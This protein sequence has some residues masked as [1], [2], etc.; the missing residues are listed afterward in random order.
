VLGSG[1]SA[2]LISAV[3]LIPCA[4]GIM[5]SNRIVQNYY[6]LHDRLF[7]WV[8][9]LVPEI[10]TGFEVNP[11]TSANTNIVFQSI[12]MPSNP[13][14]T[15]FVYFGVLPAV[16][17]LLNF[18]IPSKG[19]HRFWKIYSLAA[20]AIAL[21]FQPVWGFLSILFFPLVHYSY[22][23]IILPLGLCMLFGYTGI[24]L[25]KEKFNLPHL[26][27]GLIGAL[28]LAQALM[29]VIITYMLPSLT[30]GTR[31]V[32][33]GTI[34][35][36]GAYRFIYRK[37]PRLARRYLSWSALF[38]EA[39]LLVVLFVLTT[40]I[41]IKPIPRR[42]DIYQNIMIPALFLLSIG[43]L[44][45]RV[46]MDFFR[47]SLRRWG[48]LVRWFLSLAVI[49]VVAWVLICSSWFSQ[50]INNNEALRN[51]FVD[52]T[53]GQLR[54]WLVL[55][56][57][58]MLFVLFRI[59]VL[60]AEKMIKFFILLTIVDLFI[61][62]AHFDSVVA[63]SPYNRAFYPSASPYRDVDEHLK[64]NLDLVNYRAN[65][66]EE[67][68]LFANKNVMFKVPS[69]TGIIGYMPKRFS[70]LVK[71]FGYPPTTVL[72]YPK[73][74][75]DDDRFLDIS[76]VRYDFT[77]NH[78]VVER[79]GAL[80]RLSLLYVYRV[81][82]D[83]QS[84]L[85][86]LHNPSFNPRQEILLSKPPQ[87]MAPLLRGRSVEMVP[88]E[89]ASSD[90]LQTR[91]NVTA[92]AWLLLSESFHPGWKAYIDGHEAPI[93][94]ANYNFM[95]CFIAPGE[96]RVRFEFKPVSFNFSLNMSFWGLGIFAGILLAGGAFGYRKKIMTP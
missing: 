80:S 15:F 90:S 81:I 83:D 65:H 24:Y 91:L 1:L 41:M 96:H 94:L 69:Y 82:D 21:L 48:R 33:V 31:I 37:T 86:E 88:I 27:E 25:E 35:W 63:P 60:S 9:L 71:S 6:T 29:A 4:I 18:M 32:F 58:G 42:E 40:I 89:K 79:P 66:L 36:V 22:H 26:R 95:A 93:H 23:V 46:Y 34:V 85:K 64:T 59:R 76:A 7:L 11:L 43:L 52:F 92:P 10:V 3:R 16:F 74:S 49:A 73:D 56:I 68:G 50:F 2:L 44:S 30:W 87:E 77:E 5:E 55:G 39:L 53:I 51:Y 57:G 62:N 61:F 47:N 38:F 12:D 19:P 54:F 28:L 45:V 78:G 72:I 20:L 17:L 13:Q 75:T 67:A 14:N 8:R 70:Q 84:L